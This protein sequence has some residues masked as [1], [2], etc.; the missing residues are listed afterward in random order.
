MY[1]PDNP[2]FQKKSFHM[3]MLSHPH[4][5]GAKFFAFSPMLAFKL[6]GQT[7]TTDMTDSSQPE[8]QDLPGQDIGMLPL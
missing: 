7:G 4:Y 2:G 3:D 8:I 5:K 1:L 6:V